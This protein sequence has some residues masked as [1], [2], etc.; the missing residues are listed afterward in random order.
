MIPQYHAGT[1]LPFNSDWIELIKGSDPSDVTERNLFYR[2]E[3]GELL[4]SR[5]AKMAETTQNTSVF[6]IRK[7]GNVVLKNVD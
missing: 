2:E 7:I 1:I 3:M 4:V 5:S 6:Y